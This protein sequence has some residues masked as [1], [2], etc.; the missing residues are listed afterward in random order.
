MD[1]TQ[2]TEAIVD[3]DTVM[4]QL[5]NIN[6]KLTQLNEYQTYTAGILVF[7][8]TCVLLYFAYKFFNLFF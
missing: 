6:A 7:F 4:G 1:P 8:A 2:V 5:V 3:V